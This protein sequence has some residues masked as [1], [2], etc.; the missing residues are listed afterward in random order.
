MNWI[1]RLTKRMGRFQLLIHYSI[2]RDWQ[3]TLTATQSVR[4]PVDLSNQATLLLDTIYRVRRMSASVLST[5][6]IRTTSARASDL[7]TRHSSLIGSFCAQATA[8]FIRARH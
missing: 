4:L 2:S 5:A 3:L 6:A 1:C 8:F 7:L